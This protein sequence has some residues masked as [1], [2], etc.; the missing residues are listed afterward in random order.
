M[1]MEKH[2]QHILEMSQDFPSFKQSL[3]VFRVWLHQRELDK[4][5]SLMEGGVCLIHAWKKSLEMFEPKKFAANLI[6][7]KSEHH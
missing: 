3:M 4:V 7:H 1:C 2:L 5:S 6:C